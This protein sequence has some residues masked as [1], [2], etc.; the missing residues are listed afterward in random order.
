M[1]SKAVEVIIRE[2]RGSV[3]LL[4]KKLG[5]GYGR[6]GRMIDKMADEGIL[7]E[8]KGSKPREVLMTLQQWKRQQTGKVNETIK[9]FTTP[10][11]TAEPEKPKRPKH[12]RMQTVPRPT[13]KKTPEEDYE[14]D[15]EDIPFVVT[16]E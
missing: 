5:I 1:Y 13:Y 12:K 16:N 2:G 7:G 9:N 3:S 15:Y 14:D 6:A 10:R 4:Q 8:Y 11:S